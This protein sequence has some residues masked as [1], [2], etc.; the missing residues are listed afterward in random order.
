V[1][2]CGV[3]QTSP[4]QFGFELAEVVGGKDT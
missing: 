3:I 2:T 4:A 1:T